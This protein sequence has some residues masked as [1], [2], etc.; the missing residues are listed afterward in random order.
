MKDTVK[1]REVIVSMFVVKR[2]GEQ[3]LFDSEKIRQAILKAN[4]SVEENER[5]SD[6]SVDWVVKLV[7]EKSKK[8]GEDI[9]V[10]TI[11]DIVEDELMR[12][13][14]HH[15]AKNYI[16]YRYE[17]QLARG[18]YVGLMSAVLSKIKA[19]NVQNQNANVDER[20]AGGRVG[21]ASDV[22]MK[23]IALNYLVSEKSRQN[24]LNNEVY[25]HDLNSYPVGIHNCLSVP[26]DDLL[27][28]GFKV[29]QV[30][31]RPAQ[32]VNTAF[33]LVAVIF[34]LQSLQQFGGV[35]ATH[36]DHTMV[37]YVRK[38]FYKHF[39]DGLEV[40]NEPCQKENI[41][42]Y[43]SIVSSEYKQC[44]KTYAYAIKM[45][46]KEIYQAVEA[47]YHNLNSLQS[48][49]GHFKLVAA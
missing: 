9:S 24:H 41:A 20:S 7:E 27:A 12:L 21:E 35:S 15:L 26:I 42:D 32:S 44:Q 31:I 19:D 2:N 18:S 1:T 17:R 30:D 46:D 38:S 11:Q 33:Q 45:L 5:V 13:G 6:T 4:K 8:L 16:T 28:K 14:Y 40:T 36:I 49:S 3:Q 23:H 39:L 22:M 34:Q 37:P 25:I 10:E 48:R 43:L 47:M 29:R